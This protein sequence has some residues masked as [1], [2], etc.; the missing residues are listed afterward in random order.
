MPTVASVLT[1]LSFSISFCSAQLDILAQGAGKK[2]FGTATD[3]SELADGVYLIQLGNTTDFR[4]LTPVCI[5]RLS[6]AFSLT[7]IS[8]PGKQHEMGEY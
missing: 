1:L 7:S 6:L 5:R 8:S 2:Y 4:Q 3:N